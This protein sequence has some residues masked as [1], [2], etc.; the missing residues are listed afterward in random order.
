MVVKKVESIGRKVKVQHTEKSIDKLVKYG[1]TL[2]DL[3]KFVKEKVVQDIG[4]V[5]DQETVK[6]VK[7]SILDK[8]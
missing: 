4:R 8:I 3:E 2:S 5:F 7:E 1:G 6:R